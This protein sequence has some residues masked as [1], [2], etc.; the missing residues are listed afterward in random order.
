MCFVTLWYHVCLHVHY[1]NSAPLQ[2]ILNGNLCRTTI[3][4]R[5]QRQFLTER[6]Q[7]AQVECDGDVVSY[8]LKANGRPVCFEKWLD[9]WGWSKKDSTVIRAV[10]EKGIDTSIHEEGR[11]LGQTRG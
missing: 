7:E 2:P 10:K 11:H 6:L 4:R 5:A 3:P 1:D 9:L 8:E